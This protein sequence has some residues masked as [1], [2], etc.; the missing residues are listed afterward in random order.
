VALLSVVLINFSL[1]KKVPLLA[2]LFGFIIARAY[3]VDFVI[4]ALFINRDFARSNSL[5]GGVCVCKSLLFFV[6]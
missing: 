3:F 4:F 5:N 1:R 2:L 6:G